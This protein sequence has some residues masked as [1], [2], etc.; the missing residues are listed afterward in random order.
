MSTV[1]AVA[2][3]SLGE[4]CLPSAAESSTPDDDLYP[5]AA[6]PCNME[7]KQGISQESHFIV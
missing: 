5:A 6:C 7:L 2:M 1:D 3:V 4:I